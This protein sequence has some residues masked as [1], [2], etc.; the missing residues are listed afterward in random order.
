MAATLRETQQALAQAVRLGNASPLG[1]N[2]APARLAVYARLV[3]NN[4]LSFID[5]CFVETPKLLNDED[6][7]EAKERFIREG[8]AHSPYFQDIAGEFLQFCQQ[9]PLFSPPILA[10]M[11]FEHTQ[12]LAEVAMENIPSEFEWD[13]ETIMQL[14]P[15]AYLKQ[16]EVDFL[17]SDFARIEAQASQVLIWRNAEFD[18]LYQPL[19]ELDFWLLDYVQEQPCSYQQLIKELTA[20]DPA[21]QA[22][23]EPLYQAWQR[24]VNGEVL[25]PKAL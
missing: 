25:L 14:S 15:L 12:L 5:R 17:S 3:R 9:I 24:W 4:T 21:N 11:D 10:V 20:L 7:A 13:K 23:A 19:D 1:E 22:L 18:V 6:W 16:Y 8:K 2:V